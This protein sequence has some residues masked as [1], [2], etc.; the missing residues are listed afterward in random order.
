MGVFIWETSLIG[1][2]DFQQKL[3]ASPLQD[4]DGDMKIDLMECRRQVVLNT[5]IVVISA[6]VGLP[7]GLIYSKYCKY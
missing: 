1:F 7:T 5:A 3:P 4:A 2:V 6:S